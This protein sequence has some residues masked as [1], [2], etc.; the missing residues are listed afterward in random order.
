VQT[1]SIVSYWQGYQQQYKPIYRPS[2]TYVANTM[3]SYQR[4]APR[5][6]FMPNMGG[7]GPSQMQNQNQG[8]RRNMGERILQ[9]TPLPM[10]YTELLPD[11]VK[12]S[13]VAICLARVL[14]PPYSRFYDAN[15]KCEY[16][17]GEIGHSTENCRALKHKVQ[18]LMAHFRNRSQVWRRIP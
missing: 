11:L 13:L 15:A 17:G 16:H 18:T 10:T 5:P 6:P 4:N 9:F 1:A 14:Q 2:A 12:S 3:P 8:Q 7:S